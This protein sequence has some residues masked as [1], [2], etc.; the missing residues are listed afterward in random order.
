MNEVGT[1]IKNGDEI[2]AQDLE[3][4]GRTFDEVLY[5]ISELVVPL[6]DNPETVRWMFKLPAEELDEE[7]AD[8]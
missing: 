7:R 2:T 8:E 4:L 6:V 1:D 3:R 5:T